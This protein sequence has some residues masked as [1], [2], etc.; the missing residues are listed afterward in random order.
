MRSTMRERKEKVEDQDHR[1]TWS[2]PVGGLADKGYPAVKVVRKQDATEPPLREKPTPEVLSLP[3]EKLGQGRRKKWP[4]LALFCERLSPKKATPECWKKM[5]PG[6]KQVQSRTTRLSKPGLT[7]IEVRA[8]TRNPS[9]KPW[10][11]HSN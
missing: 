3:L 2:S 8:R 4:P 10:L 9:T 5:P 6:G 1:G 11:A 7:F